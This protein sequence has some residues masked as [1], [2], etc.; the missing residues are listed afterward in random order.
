MGGGGGGECSVFDL[1]RFADYSTE[2]MLARV[3]MKVNI[4]RIN[5]KSNADF[6]GKSSHDT[7]LYRR[8]Y[9]IRIFLHRVRRDM[10]IV[11]KSHWI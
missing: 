8:K 11:R 2:M 6:R 7:F 1:F 10:M 5:E 4:E 9:L 3:L